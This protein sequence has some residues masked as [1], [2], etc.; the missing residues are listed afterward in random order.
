MDSLPKRSRA[1]VEAA[2]HTLVRNCPFN[3]ASVQIPIAMRAVLARHDASTLPTEAQPGWKALQEGLDAHVATLG[4][5]G[6]AALPLP[7]EGDYLHHVDG[8]VDGRALVRLDDPLTPTYRL[9]DGVSSLVQGYDEATL[10]RIGAAQEVMRAPTSDTWTLK[11]HSIG[12]REGLLALDPALAGH[13][14]QA[15]VQRMI[16]TLSR[17]FEQSC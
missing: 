5:I 13:P 10:D 8:L 15:D 14:A 17:L 1:R 16:D 11:W 2:S 6:A 7:A 12:W 4:A 3:R 9:V